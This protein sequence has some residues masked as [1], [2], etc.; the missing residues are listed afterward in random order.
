MQGAAGIG[1]MLVKA[2]RAHD[3]AARGRLRAITFPDSPW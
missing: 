2:H 1:A 3:A